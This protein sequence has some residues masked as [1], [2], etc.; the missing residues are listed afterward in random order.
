L[1]IEG[2]SDSSN[3]FRVIKITSYYMTEMFHFR[4]PGDVLSV[5]SWKRNS[6]II[7]DT[8]GNELRFGGIERYVII[9]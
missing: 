5:K 2:F 4:H 7:R 6:V 1:L 3:L 9:D 8:K